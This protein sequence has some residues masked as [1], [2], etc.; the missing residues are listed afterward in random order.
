MPDETPEETPNET[1]VEAEM[2]RMMQEEI[3]G[4]D[5]GEK[6]DG[7]EAD[8]EGEEDAF[9][10]MAAALG[11]DGEGEGEAGNIDAMLEEEML[12]AMRTDTDAASTGSMAPVGAIPIGPEDSEGMQRLIDVEVNV[13]VEIGGA[14]LA[15]KDILAWTRDSIVELEP[16]ENEPVEVLVNG[17]LFAHGE[18]VVVEDTFGIRIIEMVDQFEEPHL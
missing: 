2:L 11:G 14:V 1:D 3:A 15:I 17:K 5:G 8:G 7:E 13:T 4:E 9:A 10:A 18:V 12:K 6:A 16:L